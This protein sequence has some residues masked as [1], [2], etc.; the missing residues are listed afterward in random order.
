MTIRVADIESMPSVDGD[1]GHLHQ[2]VYNLLLNALDV[3]PMGSEIRVKKQCDRRR[4]RARWT[5]SWRM[6]GLG[7]RNIWAIHIFEPF[8]STRRRGWDWDLSICRRV[9][10]AHGGTIRAGNRPEGGARFVVSLR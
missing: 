10:E 8:V 1:A 2:V 4:N 6:R 9:V 5:S 7:C 3:A